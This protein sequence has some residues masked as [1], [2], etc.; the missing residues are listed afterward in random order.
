MLTQ[1]DLI[2]QKEAQLERIQ[3]K[4]DLLLQCK[5]SL[6]AQKPSKESWSALECMDHL[7]RYGKFY[8]PEIKSKLLNRPALTSGTTV[9]KSGWLGAYFTKSMLPPGKKVNKMKTFKSMNP[10][11]SSTDPDTVAIFIE[12]LS[13]IRYLLE[14]SRGVDLNRVRTGI[15]LTRWLTFKLGD[16]FGFY[17]NHLERHVN[18]ALGAAGL[19]V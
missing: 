5:P 17:L 19:T 1:S 12:Q 11:F 18:Q 16:T 15:T 3:K 8:I 14:L 2:T 4:V 9:F 13:E 7:N 6:L 10:S